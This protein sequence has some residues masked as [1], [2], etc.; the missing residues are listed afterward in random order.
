MSDQWYQRIGFGLVLL[1]TIICIY[2]MYRIRNNLAINYA[3]TQAVDYSEFSP[4]HFRIYDKSNDTVCNRLIIV[5]P[6][7]WYL[8][9][10]NDEFYIL[11][12]ES[13]R[14][15][16]HNTTPAIQ[17]L[18]HQFVEVCLTMN[19]DSVV[20]SYT[21]NTSPV[22]IEYSIDSER[23][24]IIDAINL[25][26]KS[27]VK[28]EPNT[29]AVITG[30]GG[31]GDDTV[32]R[33]TRSIKRVDLTRVNTKKCR[34]CDLD[35]SPDQDFNQPL[36]TRNLVQMMNQ[37]ETLKSGVKMKSLRP[38]AYSDKEL[39][40]IY[41]DKMNSYHNQSAGDDDDANTSIE[42]LPSRWV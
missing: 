31:G 14:H 35:K 41:A 33:S 30:G 19:Y 36:S 7:N 37:T 18:E 11:N 28:F 17:V 6:F 5:E 34:T 32:H 22:I 9:A 27:W 10:S 25:L 40:K 42:L 24:T 4:T 21:Q 8:W 13:P 26:M 20:S 2:Y 39:Q 23:F 38:K 1:I 29:R 12:P 16:T 3:M 15:C